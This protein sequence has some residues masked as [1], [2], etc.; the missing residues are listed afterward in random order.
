MKA[1]KIEVHVAD[2]AEDMAIDGAVLVDEFDTIKEAK[3][4][5]KWWL[6]EEAQNRIE[7]TLRFGYSQVIVDGV[8]RFDFGK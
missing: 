7:R 5:A 2:N 6:T 8:V 1:R 3:A 4:R